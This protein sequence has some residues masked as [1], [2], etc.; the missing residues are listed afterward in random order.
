MSPTAPLPAAELFGGNGNDTLTG[1]SGNDL[2]FGQAGADI[3]F[4]GAGND[5]LF[6]GDGKDILTGGPGE[7]SGLRRG[8]QRRHDLEPWR[9]QRHSSRAETA[10]TSRS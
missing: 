1:G 5:Q 4:G 9:R 6:G 10:T 8:R 3:L 2:L 7:R